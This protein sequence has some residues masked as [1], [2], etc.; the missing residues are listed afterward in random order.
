MQQLQFMILC[1]FTPFKK[2]KGQPC[3]WLAELKGWTLVVNY[4]WSRTYL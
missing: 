2:F 3:T 1:I 4:N